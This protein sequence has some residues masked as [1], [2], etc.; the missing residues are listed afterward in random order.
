M[1]LWRF[2]GALALLLALAFAATGCGETIIDS[3]KTEDTI[4]A[5]LEK[6]RHEKIAAVSCPTDQKVVAGATFT[7]TLDYADG[8]QGTITLKIR[9]SDADL[10]VVGLK[11]H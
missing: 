11:S 5:N 2:S 8:K 7:C 10:D 1:N 3:G 4:Q 6:S 9:N